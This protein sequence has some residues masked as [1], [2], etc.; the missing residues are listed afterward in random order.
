MMF[1]VIAFG[2]QFQ[3]FTKKMQKQMI[4]ISIELLM[5]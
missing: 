4:Y 1:R 2:K 5:G 3:Y